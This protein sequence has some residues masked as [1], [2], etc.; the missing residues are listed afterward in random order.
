MSLKDVLIS[1]GKR[2]N[3]FIKEL[4]AEIEEVRNSLFLYRVV[5][6]YEDRPDIDCGLKNRNKELCE[7]L[8][9]Y[10]NTE[11]QKQVENT[12]QELLN[13]KHCE[14]RDSFDARLLTVIIDN[15]KISGTCGEIYSS[16]LWEN[17]KD[18]FDH[19]EGQDELYLTEYNFELYRNQVTKRCKLFGAESKHTND[20]NMLIFRDVEKLKEIQDSYNAEVPLISCSLKG[21][22]SEGCEWSTEG[23]SQNNDD[24][25][26]EAIEPLSTSN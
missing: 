12:Y 10:Y 18:T 9:L 4:Q 26:T 22:G 8:Q 25:K 23:T 20:G 14:K 6:A 1:Q 13:E 2:G 5:H 24:K 17:I 19:S 7:G 11:V 3:Q 21:E 15:L 16:D